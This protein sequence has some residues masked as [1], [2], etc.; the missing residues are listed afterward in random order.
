MNRRQFFVALAVL[1]ILAAAGA[2]V[3]LSERSAWTTAGFARRAEGDRGPAL[4]RGRR[5]RIV[6]PAGELHLMRS[7]TGWSVRER[8]G[9]AAETDRI[10]GLLVKLAEL[11]IVQSEPLPRAS[12]PRLE[13]LEPKARR[14]APAH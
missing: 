2:A 5:D 10:A 8:A 11:K 7:E 6:D 1:A 13:L 14:R 9:F 12:A 4:E 3:V